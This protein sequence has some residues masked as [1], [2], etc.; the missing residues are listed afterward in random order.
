MLFKCPVCQNEMVEKKDETFGYFDWYCEV[1]KKKAEPEI[2]EDIRV[3]P[4]CNMELAVIMG[5]GVD[6]YYCE[7]CGKTVMKENIK[8]EYR[9]L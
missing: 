8:I 9:K 2:F 6:D 1:C 5:C 3:C 7:M 4:V